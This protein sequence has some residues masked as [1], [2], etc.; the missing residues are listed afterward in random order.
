MNSSPETDNPYSPP[1][2]IGSKPSQQEKSDQRRE[3]RLVVGWYVVFAVNLIVPG[4]LAI[5]LVDRRGGLGVMIVAF[6]FLIAGRWACSAHPQ[7]AKR[8]VVGAAIVAVS[9]LFPILQIISGLTA[10]ELLS[11]FGLIDAGFETG[12]PELGIILGGAMTMI[13]GSI[14][15]TCSLII[16][17]A[18]VFLHEVF[19][20]RWKAS[21]KEI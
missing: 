5:N 21:K 12:V 20:K 4:L 6:A 17:S 15:A 14:L 8:L 2:E 10:V 11:A 18:V 16:G 7:F 3:R 19:D 13:T 9:Q 1:A